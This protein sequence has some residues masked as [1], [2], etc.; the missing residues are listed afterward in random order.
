MALP[1][2]TDVLTMDYSYAGLPFVNVPSNNTVNTQTMDWSYAGLPF[3]TNPALNG[4]ANIGGFDG[5]TSTNLQ[6]VMGV[7][8]TNLETINGVT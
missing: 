7:T 4:P 8:Y 6:A 2:S 5:V 1:S 3:V